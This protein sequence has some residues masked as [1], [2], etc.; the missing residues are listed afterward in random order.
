[1]AFSIASVAS[2]PVFSRSACS[3]R[4]VTA[5]YAPLPRNR[6][7]VLAT[8]AY[9]KANNLITMNSQ[10]DIV[11]PVANFPPSLWGDLFSSS[12]IDIQLSE[13]YFQEIEVLKEEVRNM[14]ISADSKLSEKLVLIDTIE[15]LG[16]SYHFENEIQE[17]LTLAFS[18]CFKLEP[19]EN[20]DLYIIALQFRLLR[21]LALDAPSSSYVRRQGEEIL[22]KA[23]SFS[24]ANL[25]SVIVARNLPESPLKK[26]VL[27]ALDQS[28][29][30]GTPRVES[31]RFISL[32]EEFES[33]NESLLRLAKLDFN[34]LQMLHK[35]EL[36]E[37]TRWWKEMDLIP[38]LPYARDRLVECYFWTLA[39]Y[40]EPRYSNARIMLA[41]TIA[42][43]SV[44]DD[45]YDA[46]GT[47]DELKVFTDAVQKWD[48]S[49]MDQ[50]PDYMKI[51]YR[52]LIDLCEAFDAE[53][54]PKGRSYAVNYTKKAVKEIVS[55]YYIEA[56]WFIEGHLPVFDEYM[57]QAEITSGTYFL[58]V[59]AYLGVD[60]ATT[61]VFD[62][63]LAIPKILK[64]SNIVNRVIDDIATYECEKDRGQLTTGIDC[65]M[66]EHGV[67]K[68]VAIQCFEEIAENGWKDLNEG[69]LDNSV[70]M[71]IL[72]RVFN[73]SRLAE[74]TYKHKQDGY[75]YPERGLKPHIV[76]LLLDSF[77]I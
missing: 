5:D 2:L 34:L 60:S 65:Y 4:S 36:S 48:M 73:W 62:W 69:L 71:E 68:Q 19:E 77:E 61:E 1:M 23:F 55:S 29:Y 58:T 53:L 44:I 3:V 37:L 63:L 28:L 31:R 38:R 24:K 51:C 54:S 52:A 67:S 15:R 30:R 59:V 46:Y 33:K 57:S 8:A 56:K 35:K 21:Q 66:K 25:E 42:V 76:A 43:I 49:E 26:Q 75:T 47:I 6:P 50:L 11:R 64:A 22:D 9:D 45:T 12:N 13:L 18:G 39:I 72:M 16:L 14:L 32:Y 10:K 20:D 40:F 74:I 17:Q 27:H 41:K 7:N 70:S